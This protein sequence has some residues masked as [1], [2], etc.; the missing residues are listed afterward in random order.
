MVQVIEVN[1]PYRAPRYGIGKSDTIDA[2]TATRPV[3]SGTD[4]GTLRLY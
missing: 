1:R 2:A 3:L 4:P